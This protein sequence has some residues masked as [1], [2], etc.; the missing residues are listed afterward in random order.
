MKEK[1]RAALARVGA[2]TRRAKELALEYAYLMTLGAALTVVAASA[3]YTWQL[4]QE[5]EI[6]AAAD[7][8]E[9][10]VSAL[11]SPT[12]QPLPTAVPLATMAP[13]GIASTVRLGG[14]TVRPV[15]GGVLRECDA[16]APVYWEALSCF[17]PHAG[18]DLAGSE[19]EEVL[20]A[21]DGTVTRTVRDELWGW[22]VEVAQTD[23]QTAVYAGM[24]G[25]LVHEGQNVT[26]S[27]TLGAL[28]D[29]V[30]CE[31]EL[32]AHLHMELSSDGEARDPE[33]IL[34]ER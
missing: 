24:A 8:P 34:P 19:G 31:A 10:Q 20:L 23:G 29:A 28:M 15:P 30:P 9:V 33:S 3:L 22:R 2:V 32:G 12:R 14:T 18:L 1:I 17:Q 5:G 4:R 7:A 13:M 21:M 26:R 11:P 6:Q 25:S 27:Q 16:A